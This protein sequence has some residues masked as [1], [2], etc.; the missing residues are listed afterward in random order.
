[1]IIKDFK[2]LWMDLNLKIHD[3]LFEGLNVSSTQI[4][5]YWPIQDV[6][7]IKN[8][9]N[10]PSPNAAFY[11]STFSTVLNRIIINLSLHYLHAVLEIL[12]V[13]YFFQHIRP[14]WVCYTST[15][16]FFKGNCLFQ[17]LYNSKPEGFFK[18]LF[19]LT[20]DEG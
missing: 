8:S 14:K 2:I 16:R 1:M 4:E 11:N 5:V 20:S 6:S 13:L 10:K 3:Y 15:F 17:Q 18:F 12:L 19:H 7:C 9:E